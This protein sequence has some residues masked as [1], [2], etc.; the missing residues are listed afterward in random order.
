MINGDINTIGIYRAKIQSQEGNKYKIFIPSL[1]TGK[2]DEIEINKNSLLL[3]DICSNINSQLQQNEMCWVMFENGNMNYPVIIENDLTT[4][5]MNFNGA[6]VNN[7]GTDSATF[8][9][10]NVS[11]GEG[12]EN[13]DSI[14]NALIAAGLNVA[15][16]C[17]ALANIH[18]ESRFNPAAYNPNDPGGSHGICQWNVNA[19][20]W[21]K[22]KQFCKD[23]N[24]DYN[25]LT[26]QVNYLI[27]ELQNNYSSTW[28]TLNGVTNDASGAMAASE[29]F[30]IHFEVPADRYNEAKR[31][32]P[33]AAELFKLYSSAVAISSP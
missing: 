11:T 1:Y 16:A 5:I 10:G 24:F 12:N 31:R 30:T 27:F 23:N 17:G 13:R 18:H 21:G 6:F 28:N 33:E 25:S 8:V 15:G 32:S 4:A 22:C 20:R 29:F 2:Q 26:G 7:P 9:G 3:A 14:F 19:G